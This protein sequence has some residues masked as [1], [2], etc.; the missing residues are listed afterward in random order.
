M[1]GTLL[2]SSVADELELSREMNKSSNNLI[3]I[4]Q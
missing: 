4:H 1:Q 3:I 2:S